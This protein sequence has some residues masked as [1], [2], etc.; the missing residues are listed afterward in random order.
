MLSMFLRCIL[1][2]SMFDVYS[3]NCTVVL[4]LLRKLRLLTFITRFVAVD[5][6]R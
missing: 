5:F 1:H 2:I 4:A 6:I 3:K